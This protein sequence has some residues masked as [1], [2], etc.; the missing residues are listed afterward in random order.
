[1]QQ[2][3]NSADGFYKRAEDSA[4]KR[5]TIKTQEDEHEEEEE[6]WSCNIF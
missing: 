5:E 1:M 6:Q 4:I 2:Y 3:L